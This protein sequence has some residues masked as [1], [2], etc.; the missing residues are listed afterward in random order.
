MKLLESYLLRRT[1]T[2]FL[3]ALLPVLAIIW[4]T[5]VLQRIDL[6]TDTGA[7][8]LSFMK[9]AT[10]ILP[11]IITLV[12]PFALVIGVAQTLTTMNTDSE[13]TV[14]EAAGASR[15]TTLRPIVLLAG[16]LSLFSFAMSNGLEP[17][18]RVAAREMVAAA[19]ADLLSSIIEEKSFRKISDGLYIQIS[20]RMSGRILKGLFVSD[21]RNP[22]FDLIYYARE[23]AVDEKGTSLIMRN[24]EVHRKV[25]GGDVSVIRFDSYSFDL[26][27]MMPSNQKAMLRAGDRTLGFLLNPDENDQNYK[28]QPGEYRV[29]LHRR[30][31]EWLFPL[32]F[33]LVALVIAGEAK[34][35]R[36]ARL[37][38]LASTMIFVFF[39]RWLAFYVSSKVEYQPAFIPMVYLVPLATIGLCL[40]LIATRNK[41][42][43]VSRL[44]RMITD[45]VHLLQARLEAHR[46]RT[47]ARS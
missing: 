7:S 39:L 1:L 46:A 47:K 30:L 9:L 23:G 41:L 19:Y 12:L 43:S 35:H 27:D 45:G 26:S 13:L 11:S 17:K 8:V 20:E 22:A 10:L 29:E 21:T 24:G 5:Q 15:A 18:V 33:A 28:D 36:E 2:M 3:A 4:T 44:S 31:S 32:A 38:P 42:R 6:V 37:H 40:Y 14:I 16:A 34:S 25:A